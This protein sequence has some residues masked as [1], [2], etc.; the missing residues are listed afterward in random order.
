MFSH[1]DD[2][3]REHER[4]TSGSPRRRSDLI[5][6]KR[7]LA[8]GPSLPAVS[9]PRNRSAVEESLAQ[10]PSRHGVSGTPDAC[11]VE[12]P[13]KLLPKRPASET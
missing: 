6:G 3:S 4:R 9:D 1:A 10:C 2:H 8:P 11:R 12:S 13:A 7:R 5:L